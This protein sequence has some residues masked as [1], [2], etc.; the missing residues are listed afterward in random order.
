MEKKGKGKHLW[1]Y[2]VC[3]IKNSHV[4][5]TFDRIEYVY[6]YIYYTYIHIYAEMFIVLY[7]PYMYMS[8]IMLFCFN[9]WS[10]FRA[11]TFSSKDKVYMIL[12]LHKLYNYT[13]LNYQKLLLSFV[14]VLRI[15]TLY[16]NTMKLYIDAHVMYLMFLHHKYKFLNKFMCYTY[17]YILKQFV[18][19]Y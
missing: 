1:G 3:S 15:K 6:L 16:K 14:Y 17:I 13:S 9:L 18:M 11:Y 10:A 19:E 4:Y 2:V 5:Y 7:I 12:L 8:M